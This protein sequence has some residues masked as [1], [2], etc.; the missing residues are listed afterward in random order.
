MYTALISDQKATWTFLCLLGDAIGLQ[1]VTQCLRN[2]PG[3]KELRVHLSYLRHSC[4]QQVGVFLNIGLLYHLPRQ[5]NCLSSA[6]PT[7]WDVVL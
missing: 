5:Q 1:Y 3:C 2:L 6:A 7:D 4:M